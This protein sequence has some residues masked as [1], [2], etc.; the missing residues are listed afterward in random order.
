MDKLANARIM[1]SAQTPAEQ[2][3]WYHLRAHR[4]LGIKFKRQP[5]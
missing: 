3:M 5:D 4:F 2:R 1:R